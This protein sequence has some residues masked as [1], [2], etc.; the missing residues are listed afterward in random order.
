MYHRDMGYIILEF[1]NIILK[2]SYKRRSVIRTGPS[3]SD[4]APYV[5]LGVV[6]RTTAE[7]KPVLGAGRALHA[8]AL[9]PTAIL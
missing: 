3:G 5:A 9:P 7:A 2:V 8:G 1:Q 6:S 4:K